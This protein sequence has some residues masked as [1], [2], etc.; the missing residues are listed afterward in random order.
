MT[1]TGALLGAALG[2]GALHAE[3]AGDELLDLE[4]T[5]LLE[6]PVAV[7]SRSEQRTADATAAV[8]VIDREALRRSGVQRLPVA[9][10]LVPVLH[11]G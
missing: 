7:A 8:Y 1:R 4:L 6:L 10:R 3:P 2:V 5:Q 9:L 11:V